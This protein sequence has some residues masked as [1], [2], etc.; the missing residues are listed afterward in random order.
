LI[1]Q[2]FSLPVNSQENLAPDGRLFV[3]MCARDKEFC[4]RQTTR[5]AS[6]HFACLNFW[7]EELIHEYRQWKVGGFINNN[8]KNITCSYNHTL[9]QQLR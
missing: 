6:I 8:N 4:S 5:S 9:L 3:E 2:G 7:I 1:L